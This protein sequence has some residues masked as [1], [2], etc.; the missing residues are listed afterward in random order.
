MK[1]QMMDGDNTGG[2]GRLEDEGTTN[3]GM[4]TEQMAGMDPLPEEMDE[5]NAD[6]D[7]NTL[8]G[9]SDAGA[10]P[11]GDGDSADADE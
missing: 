4:T 2:G 5:D 11:V 9:T 3:G 1:T 7:S 10:G 6:I 8:G